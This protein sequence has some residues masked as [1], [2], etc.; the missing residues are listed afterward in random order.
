MKKHKQKAVNGKPVYP[1]E[2]RKTSENDLGSS[3]I[4]GD[5][6]RG[7]VRRSWK[8]VL[9]KEQLIHNFIMLKYF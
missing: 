9:R 6:E 2:D 4:P 7:G 3:N 8:R 1:V 5:V